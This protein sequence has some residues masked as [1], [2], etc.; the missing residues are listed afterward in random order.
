[1]CRIATI[2]ELRA[3][4]SN[5]F[6][7]FLFFSTHISTSFHPKVREIKVRKKSL[8]RARRHVVNVAKENW[9]NPTECVHAVLGQK[10]TLASWCQMGGRGN[11]RC[12]CRV[13]ARVDSLPLIGCVPGSKVQTAPDV[14]PCLTQGDERGIIYTRCA[15]VSNHSGPCI[16][17]GSEVRMNAK[18]TKSRGFGRGIF[19]PSRYWSSKQGCGSGESD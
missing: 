16:L 1:M 7:Y 19:Q 13:F 9:R 14:T 8:Q 15:G 3:H 5:I 4:Q 10:K 18:G 17:Q 6:A 11:P 2:T 12:M